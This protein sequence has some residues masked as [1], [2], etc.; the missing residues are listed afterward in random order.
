MVN[1]GSWSRCGMLGNK[2]GRPQGRQVSEFSTRV[3]TLSSGLGGRGG[4]Y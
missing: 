4:R 3:G 1:N 2:R